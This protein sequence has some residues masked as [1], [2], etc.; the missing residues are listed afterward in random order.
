MGLKARMPP[1]AAGHQGQWVLKSSQAQARDLA[2]GRVALPVWLPTAGQHSRRNLNCLSLTLYLLGR[3]VCARAKEKAHTRE[4]FVVD[5][6]L[7]CCGRG[8]VD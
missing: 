4:R 5:D 6:R 8:N 1:Y 7:R 3:C 2:E